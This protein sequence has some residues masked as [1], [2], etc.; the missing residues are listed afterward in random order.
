MENLVHRTFPRVE[1]NKCLSYNGFDMNRNVIDR[2][3]GVALNVSQNGLQLET[4][5]MIHTEYILL[6][7]FDF[8]SNYVAAKGKVVYSNKDASGKFKTGINLY[9]TPQ[10]N[11]QFIKTLIKS[12]HYQ[13]KVPVYIS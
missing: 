10:E 1:I 5:C 9:G 13:K 12:Y 4:D 2:Y 8:N 11:I 3:M 6:M 7:F